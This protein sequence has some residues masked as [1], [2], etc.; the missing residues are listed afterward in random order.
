[1]IILT[2]KLPSIDVNVPESVHEVSSEQ[3][4]N[5]QHWASSNNGNGIRYAD[6]YNEADTGCTK[7]V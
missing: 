2:R 7:L 6:Y 1:M 3:I 5:Y 4:E